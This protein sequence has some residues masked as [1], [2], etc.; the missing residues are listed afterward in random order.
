[1]V[2]SGLHLQGWGCPKLCR[3]ADKDTSK[4]KKQKGLSKT[5]EETQNSPGERKELHSQP[6]DWQ[7]PAPTNHRTPALW[8]IPEKRERLRRKHLSARGRSWWEM[9]P[10]HHFP[11]PPFR[12]LWWMKPLPRLMGWGRAPQLFQMIPLPAAFQN[13]PRAQAGGNFKEKKNSYFFWLCDVPVE[14]QILQWNLYPADRAF[15]TLGMCRWG[16]ALPCLPDPW[17]YQHR[18]MAHWHLHS[19]AW[20]VVFGVF[21]CAGWTPPAPRASS[22]IVTAL[23]WD[24][25]S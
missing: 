19:S 9:S 8:S 3:A 4:Y 23:S 17:I 10:I 14:S 20:F 1:M 11:S 12:V 18:L 5:T 24:C 16:S 15:P 22:R 2:I 7:G 25:K 21:I 6:G 13:H